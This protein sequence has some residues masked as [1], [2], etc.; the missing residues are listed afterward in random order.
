MNFPGVGVGAGQG[1]PPAMDPVQAQV[2][3]VG[4]LA[5]RPFTLALLNA[6]LLTCSWADEQDD[7]VVRRQVGP[8]R[9]DGIRH[10]R[11]IR[12]VHG[13][14]TFSL[15]SP[16]LSPLFVLGAPGFTR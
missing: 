13:L 2:K 6:T 10:G 9:S 7:G 15:S 14:G 16:L 3:A 1:D 4:S 5:L 12:H 8:V 11:S